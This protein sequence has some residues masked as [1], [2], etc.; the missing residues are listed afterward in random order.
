MLWLQSSGLGIVIARYLAAKRE[1]LF[2]L[3]AVTLLE[4][5]VV[6]GRLCRSQLQR[7]T[8]LSALKPAGLGLGFED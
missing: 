4:P 3:Q 8:D 1:E 7:N 6:L 5:G 2:G